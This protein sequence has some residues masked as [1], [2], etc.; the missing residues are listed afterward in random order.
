MLMA[1]FPGANR[2]RGK[3]YCPC[4]LLTTQTLMV[5]PARFAPTITPSIAPSAWELTLPLKA[6][7]WLDPQPRLATARTINAAFLMTRPPLDS[8]AEPMSSEY[9]TGNTGAT[10]QPDRPAPRHRPRGVPA[11]AL[12]LRP[13]I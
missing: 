13:E 12:T 9:A 4:V 3:V 10:S 5:E 11:L 1:Y 8:H 2:S 6:G 7:L